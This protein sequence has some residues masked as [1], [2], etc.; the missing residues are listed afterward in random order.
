VV[1][2]RR[3]AEH[4]APVAQEQFEP[5]ELA[6]SQR[7]G[8]VPSADGSRRR[9]E[10]EVARPQDGRPLARIAPQQGPQPGEQLGEGERLGQV[11]VGPGVEAVD[12]IADRVARGEHDDR[13]PPALVTEPAA[14]VE[15]VRRRDHRVEHDG[16][17]GELASRPQS[18]FAVGGDVD[19]VSLAL[20]APLEERGHLL[21]V[22]DNAKAHAGTVTPG[23]RDRDWPAAA[24]SEWGGER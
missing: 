6:G 1:D 24:V 18:V 2:D 3:A 12:A 7:D 9:V 11:V 14:H 5:G 22:L 16:V 17:V 19:G 15:P 10:L 13:H 8:G 20:Q 21:V 4:L 23:G